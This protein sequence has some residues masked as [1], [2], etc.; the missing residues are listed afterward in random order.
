MGLLMIP[1]VSEGRDRASLAR[2]TEA[3][4]SAATVLDVHSDEVHGRSV[5]TLTGEA[6]ALVEAAV[7]L[8][9][10]CIETIDLTRH[11][12]VHPRLGVLD[13]C[14]FEPHETTIE[15]AIGLAR[16]AGAAIAG[17]LGVPVFLYGAA[18][19]EGRSLPELRRGGLSGLVERMEA[20]LL[21]DLGPATVDPSV[22]V[23]C[24]GARE[25]LIA[26]NVWMRCEVSVARATAAAVR[27]SGGGLRG[28]R[29]LG[30]QIDGLDC[31][32][33]MNLVEPHV[34]GID[35][36]FR[37]V[38]R[39]ARARGAEITRTEIV[40]LVPQRFMPDPDAEAARLMHPPGRSVESLLLG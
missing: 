11:T 5:F 40:G 21:P 36:A 6:P 8:G 39:E 34:A 15:E 2:L 37:A 7:A 20:G 13:G 24:V 10:A 33:S 14:P 32:V 31:Q 9:A 25:M 27:E 22:G 26:F 4:S 3:V 1:N 23:V 16:S 28:V 18:S 19:T 12:G 38:G 35:A 30:F 29:A 17:E